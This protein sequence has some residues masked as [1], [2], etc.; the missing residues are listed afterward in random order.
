MWRDYVS[1]LL[2]LTDILFIPPMTRVG[3]RRWNDTDRGK[4]KNSEKKLSQC[5]H[6]SHMDW[7][8]REPGPTSWGAGGNRLSH[9]T[10]RP[11]CSKTLYCLSYPGSQQQVASR[12]AMK[13]QA[14]SRNNGWPWV[15][16]RLGTLGSR[17]I[18]AFSEL[19]WNCRPPVV[20]TG[21]LEFG[22]GWEP[23][24]LGR[25]TRFQSGKCWCTPL[26]QHSEPNLHWMFNLAHYVT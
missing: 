21:D 9:G 11:V 18:H 1:E 26:Q 12:T 13:L 8:G 19:P 3:E 22:R 5:H 7:P 4:P 10:A 23:L 16:K 2:P 24:A 15:W 17:E 6:K 20:T 25:Y 14:A